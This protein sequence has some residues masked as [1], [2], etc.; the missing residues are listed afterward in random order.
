[1]FP[2]S[3]PKHDIQNLPL[4]RFEGKIHLIDTLEKL[5]EATQVLQKEPMLGFDTET[6]PTFVKGEYNYTALVQF[7][8]LTEAWLIR[9]K[10]MGLPADLLAIL[11]DKKIKK[12][13]ISIR[14][15]LKE[16]K[17]IRPFKPGGFIDLND[18]AKDMGITQMGVKNLT[19]IFLNRRISKSQQTSNWENPVLSEAQKYYASTDAWVCI[20]MYEMLD[21]K[22]YLE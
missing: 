17:K 16:L 5:R 7:T 15:D 21:R 12:I 20:K 4:L 2:T 18:I 14:D 1:M 10:D 13:G 8:T 3:I 11:Q 6:K 19:G 9:I 22:G